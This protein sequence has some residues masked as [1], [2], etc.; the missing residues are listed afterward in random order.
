MR[1]TLKDVALHAGVSAKTVSNVVNGTG[2]F[3]P[4]VRARVE[5]A[6]AAL[7]YVPN[8]SAR[9][10]RN[11]R[12]GLICLALPNLS[13][14]YSAELI[15]EFA[16]AAAGR[17]LGV[18]IEETGF[19]NYERERH[20][21]S[22]AR[23]HLI[24][25]LIMSPVLLTSAALQPTPVTPPMVFLGEVRQDTTDHVWVDNV[26]ASRDMVEHLIGLGHRRIAMLGRFV[27]ESARLRREGYRQALT[28]AG[29]APSADLEI[30][31]PT[32][33]TAAAAT[34]LDEYLDRC[35]L[36]DAIFCLTDSQA[37]GALNTLWRRGIR[38]PDDVSV[39]GYDDITDGRYAVPPL[40]T[41]GIDKARLA[42]AAIDLLI[43]RI[44]E[45]GRR[46]RRVTIPYRILPR[47]SSKP[48]VRRPG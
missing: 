20:L 16:L 48:A 34:A 7:N 33:T 23:R 17:D 21:L 1:V 4:E 6:V 12:S 36:P 31:N 8:F 28:A 22:Q 13:S 11:G 18:Q 46:P 9:G 27:S 14:P 35:P 25:G 41:V 30:P 5:S 15:R 26:A 2:R 45:P 24:D 39:A 29:L 40:T 19:D 37:L 43:E 38:V 47:E 42:E 44:A 3:S 32:W 10:L